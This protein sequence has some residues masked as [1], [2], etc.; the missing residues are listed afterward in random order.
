MG[1]F[2]RFTRQSLQ[3]VIYTSEMAI[4]DGFEMVSREKYTFVRRRLIEALSASLY[5]SGMTDI[6]IDERMCS[7]VGELE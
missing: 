3:I 4:W 2:F 7:V 5:P 6:V 1:I